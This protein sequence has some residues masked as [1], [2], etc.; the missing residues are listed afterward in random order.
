MREYRAPSNMVVIDPTMKATMKTVGVPKSPTV[1]ARKKKA[2]ARTRSAITITGRRA[3]RSRR[4]PPTRP[5]RKAG[6][7]SAA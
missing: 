7:C 6:A 5:I 3:Q 4:T 2:P 1:A